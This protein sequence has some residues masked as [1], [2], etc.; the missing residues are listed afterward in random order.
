MSFIRLLSFDIKK[1]LLENTF[2]S[3]DITNISYKKLTLKW[4]LKKLNNAICRHFLIS[5]FDVT[6]LAQKI[7]PK[8]NFK[9]FDNAIY[10][11]LIIKCGDVTNVVQKNKAEIEF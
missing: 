10:R 2:I 1:F 11:Q 6:S 8:L 3:F 4:H 5:S 9:I 7:T